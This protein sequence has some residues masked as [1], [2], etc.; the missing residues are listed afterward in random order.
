MSITREVSVFCDYCGNWQ[1][2]VHVT[3]RE[4]RAMVRKLGWVRRRN[5]ANV[6]QDVCA[7]CAKKEGSR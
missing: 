4:L 5:S 1:R 6:L 7:F 2:A 3:P